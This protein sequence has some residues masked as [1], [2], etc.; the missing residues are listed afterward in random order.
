MSFQALNWA[1]KVVTGSQV[2]KHVLITIANY[3]DDEGSC[4]VGQAR[5][6]RDTELTDRTVRD[7]LARLEKMGVISRTRR[8]GDDGYR[9]SDLIRLNASYRNLLPVGPSHLPEPPAG[10]EGEPTGISRQPT[11]ISP[12]KNGREI[13][14]NHHEPS[15]INQHTRC[16]RSKA[17]VKPIYSEE[18]T[19]LWD[20]VPKADNPGSKSDAAKSFNKLTAEDRVQC[21]QGWLAYLDFLE[22][23]RAKR[24]DYPIKQ[25]VSFINGRLWET[26]LEGKE[27]NHG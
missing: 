20:C 5:I 18:F 14:G 7:S 15:D 21:I 2:L 19:M 26:Y 11:G 12:H 6:A 4:F 3:C 27:S 9:T 25:L 17:N 13:P 10:N 24:A 22:A 16:A 23:K 8:N 1:V